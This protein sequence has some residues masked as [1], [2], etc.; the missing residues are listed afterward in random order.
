[1]C[2]HLSIAKLHCILVIRRHAQDLSLHPGGFI[3]QR[4]DVVANFPF[5]AGVTIWKLAEDV[6]PVANS[7][8]YSTQAVAHQP[9]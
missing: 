5:I 2:E 9:R 3:K 6:I 4:L 8:S 7:A 1:M